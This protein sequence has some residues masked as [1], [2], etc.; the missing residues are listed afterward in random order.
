MLRS[1]VLKY[2]LGKGIDLDSWQ[3]R[4]IFIQEQIGSDRAKED[5]TAKNKEFRKCKSANL[6]RAAWKFRLLDSA[7]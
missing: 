1:R 6:E 2:T 4:W 7:A 3:A 5:L